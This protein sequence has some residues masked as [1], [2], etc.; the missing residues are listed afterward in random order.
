MD[1]LR[2]KAGHRHKFKNFFTVHLCLLSIFF[3]SPFE[4]EVHPGRENKNS[5]IHI[6]T[7]E[8]LR[9]TTRITFS[10]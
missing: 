6:R 3:L 5:F 10:S 1:Y 2:E 7:K 8:S 9:G 4:R